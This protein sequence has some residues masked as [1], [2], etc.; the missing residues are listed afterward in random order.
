MQLR[1]QLRTHLLTAR[2][3]S[4]NDSLHAP[5]PLMRRL[6]SY[7]RSLAPTAHF[8][9]AE[10]CMR[11]TEN[12]GGLC[13]NCARTAWTPGVGAADAGS[14][15]HAGLRDRLCLES[16]AT[17]ARNEQTRE[18]TRLGGGTRSALSR[19]GLRGA[20]AWLSTHGVK[21]SS[22]H[23]GR[24]CRSMRECVRGFGRSTCP[25]PLPSSLRECVRG[26]RHTAGKMRRGIKS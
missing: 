20:G 12:L 25:A 1:M 21:S 9:Q 13:M 15:A 2:S 14:Q 22:L 8:M 7:N 10:D 17:F 4:R 26:F 23:E 11:M 16:R 3:C 18:Q 19:Q 5:A 6:T 24:R